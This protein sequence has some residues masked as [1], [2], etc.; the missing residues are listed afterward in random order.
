MRKKMDSKTAVI[1]QKISQEIESGVWKS[2]SQ[3]PSETEMAKLYQVSRT[4]IRQALQELAYSGKIIKKRG[5]GNFVGDSTIQYGINDLVSITNLIRQGGYKVSIENV[6]IEIEKPKEK[7]CKLLEL[8]TLDP[9][10]RV[11]RIILADDNPVVFERIIYPA[12]VLEG[13]TEEAFYGSNFEMLK[14]KGINIQSS[15]GMICPVSAS[16]HM[17]ELMKLPSKAPLLLM[18]SVFKD[19]NQQNVYCVEDYFTDKFSFPIRRV[20]MNLL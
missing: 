6:S 14:Q 2:G 5:I 8:N 18:D 9:I 1:I 16:K 17:S 20:R 13:I 12:K 15:E 10:Y 19:Q 11:E 7:Y 4:T 3:L